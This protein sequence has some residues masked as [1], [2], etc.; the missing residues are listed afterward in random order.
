MRIIAPEAMEAIAT[1]AVVTGGAAEILCDPPVRVFHGQGTIE[2][3]GREYVGIDHAT[4][5]DTTGG[6]LGGAA[7]SD[8]IRLS[9]IDPDTLALLDAE[10]VRGAP[11]AMYRLIGDAA[12]RRLLDARVFRRGRIDRIDTE[13]TI[14]GEAVVL[15]TVEGA[16]RGL[17]RRGG[18]LRSDADQRLIDPVDGGMRR[19]SYAAEK[20]L[21]W[22]GNR[23]ARAGGVA[24]GG[25]LRGMLD[26]TA[27]WIRANS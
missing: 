18:R 6:A 14:G 13:E 10:Q 17:G 16:A 22:G 25:G 4:L 5:V 7:Q 27:D 21:Y 19:L 24:S 3:G 20:M 1:G 9:G 2:I 8:V 15:I 11:V 23:P 12:G 26:D